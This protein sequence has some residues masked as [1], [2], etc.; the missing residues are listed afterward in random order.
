MARRL[1]YLSIAAI[2]ISVALAGFAPAWSA[3]RDGIIETPSGIASPSD[4]IRNIQQA[5][6]KMGYYSG[7]V[8]GR[9]GD[10]LREAIEAYQR[11]V[12]RTVDGKATRE[13]AE[14][15]ETQDKVGAMLKRLETAR[16]EKIAAAREALLQK[17]QTRHLLQGDIKEV[18]D[19]TRDV[20]AC[21]AKPTQSCLLDEAV[22]SAKGIFK[23]ELRDWAY[24][25]ILVSQAKAGM[26]DA[27]ISTVRRIGD[28]RLIIVALRDISRVLAQE[29]MST[30]RVRWPNSF[31]TLASGW[32]RSP[33]SP[34][35]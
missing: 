15:M 7:A 32:R 5:L 30:K 19:P 20:S 16:E 23:P 1:R 26:I 18:A 17:E 14:H 6:T 22:E 13:L 28:A 4:V 35:F 24:G 2:S 27:A 33:P 8:D 25:E 29:G 3:T 31:P 11:A 21:F 10:A 12:G 34:R 9:M